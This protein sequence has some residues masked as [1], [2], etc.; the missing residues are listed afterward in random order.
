MIFG[1][2]ELSFFGKVASQLWNELPALNS[3]KAKQYAETYLEKLLSCSEHSSRVIDKMHNNFMYLGL[4]SVL[5]PHAHIIHCRR[6]PIDTCLSIYFQNFIAPH[7]YAYNL[8]KIGHWYLQ[9]QRC[10]THWENVLPL[11]I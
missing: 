2:G 10:M 6:N 5:F 4:I 8:S 11:P 9:Y 7:D 3:L 1:A